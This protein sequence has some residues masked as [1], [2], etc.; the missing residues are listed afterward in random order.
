MNN[1]FFTEVRIQ[2]KKDDIHLQGLERMQW[3]TFTL[4]EAQVVT[5]IEPSHFKIAIGGCAKMTRQ[6]V[7]AGVGPPTPS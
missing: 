1:A 6:E 7:S 5:E 4:P 3:P 2:S